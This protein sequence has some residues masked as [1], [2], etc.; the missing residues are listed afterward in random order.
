M[1][2]P[3][4]VLLLAAL[5]VATDCCRPTSVSACTTAV[6]TGKASADGRPILWKSRDTKSLPRNEVV[7]YDGE[8]Y[9]VLAVVNDEDH[10]KVW[11]GVNSAGFCIEN[12]VSHDLDVEGEDKGPG[13]GRIMKVALETCATV[14]DFRSLLEN[15]DATGRQTEGNFGVIDAA[16]G[17]ALFE[18][19][20]G[21]AHV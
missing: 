14:A 12:S 19:E 1:P 6:I 4:A 3:L 20:I 2:R 9:R 8:S 13:N 16:G 15:T 7:I 11:M 5:P 18:A 17:A 10:E 21:R